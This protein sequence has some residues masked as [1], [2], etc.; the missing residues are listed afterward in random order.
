MRKKN[1]V[2]VQLF[3]NIPSSDPAE[4]QICL[5]YASLDIQAD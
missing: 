4:C 5:V 3:I 2:Q 1:S